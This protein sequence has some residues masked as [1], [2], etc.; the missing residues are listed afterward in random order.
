MKESPFHIEDH[1]LLFRETFSSEQS[2]RRNGGTPTGDA[3]SFSNGVGTFGG[4]NDYIAYPGIYYSVTGSV[5]IVFKSDITVTSRVL[6]DF[7]GSA[8]GA[9]FISGLGSP[10]RMRGSTGTEY[11]NGIATDAIT[12]G[13]WNDFI[14]TGIS[15]QCAG[16]IIVGANYLL[17]G[18]FTGDIDLIEIYLGILTAEEVSN[19]YEGKRF[20]ELTGQAEVLN[21]SAQS[22]SIIDRW[23]AT[24][25]NTDVGV[26]KQGDA[27][28]MLFN[29][30]TSKLD[31]GDITIHLWFKAYGYGENNLGLLLNNGGPN[32]GT[33]SKLSIYI[34][35]AIPARIY[36]RSNTAT[37]V[38]SGSGVYSFN[39]WACLT[40]TRTS[41][42]VTNFY[43]NG[44][45]AGSADQAGGTPE[46]NTTNLII[47]NDA[48][49]IK[50]WDGLI[51]GVRIYSG[52][53]T[54]AE[55]SQ[56]YTNERASY[57]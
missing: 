55:I 7:R 27:R 25:T 24:L 42:G 19:L 17:G 54:A 49:G 16:N 48:T 1:R 52:L 29:G 18:D 3:V 43:I 57:V 21:I 13:E 39:E 15:F 30:S 11:V 8:S 26:V 56:M 37:L 53:L 40:I 28:C 6:M 5:R 33:D 45:A 9:G 12:L 44:V 35:S 51:S 23:G 47:G 10:E 36:M 41:T 38:H 46:A 34:I 50:T 2:V 20:T 22:G 14:V 31:C 4:S 32:L